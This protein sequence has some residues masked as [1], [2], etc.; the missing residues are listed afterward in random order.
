MS[1]HNSKKKKETPM[2]IIKQAKHA[3]TKVALIGTSLLLLAGIHSSQ[4][5][6]IKIASPSSYQDRE[7]EECFCGDSEP[8]YRYQQVFPAADFAALGNKPHWIVGFG[9]RADQSVTS[10]HTAYL[11]DNEVRLSTTQQGPND[12]SLQFDANHGSDVIQFYRGP[13]TMVADVAGHPGPKEFYHA[14]FPAGVTPFLYDP[15]QGNLLFDFIAWQGESP[16]ILADQIPGLQTVVGDPSATQ[17]DRGSAAIFQFTFVPAIHSTNAQI[18]INGSY[19]SPDTSTYIQINAGQNTIAPWVVG[20]HSVEVGDA[21]GNGFITGPAF[22]GAQFLDLNGLQRGQIAQALAT[23][24]GS[25]YTVTFAYTDNYW[26]PS[27]TASASATVRVFDSLGDR[28]N[29]TITHTGAVAG[30][31]H[32]TVFTGQFTALEN[33]TTLEFTSLSNS[34]SGHSGGII[35]DAVQVFEGAP[36]QILSVTRV[37]GSVA[38]HVRGIPKGL[39]R[40]QASGDLSAGSFIDIA[41]V[42]ADAAG[43][44]HFQDTRAGITKSLYR[45]VSP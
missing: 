37:G 11:P 10:P 5:A 23:T 33:T 32:W 25:L 22:E 26:E 15:S 30:N 35:L 4:A 2:K 9:P 18:L 39:H 24:P 6:E 27:S 19:E 41:T 38:L 29:Q 13:L 31:Y 44:M 43:L 40:I 14:D 45:V 42:T 3:C 8:P 36:L 7:G 16:K 34:A 21:V 1:E 12:L 28:L 20:L 17:G